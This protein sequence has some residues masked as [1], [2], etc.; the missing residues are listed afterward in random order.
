MVDHVADALHAIGLRD[1]LVEVGGELR[2]AGRRP[3][4][5]P[6][7]VRLDTAVEGI[8]SLP[9]TDR[10]VATSG[11]RWHAHAQGGRRWA[12]TIDPRS[13]EPA[14]AALSSVTVL[15]ARC[16]HADALTTALTVLGPVDGLA[17]AQHHG[18]GALFVCRDATGDARPVASAA[19]PAFAA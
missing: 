16:M 18:I 13:G 17:F 8:A 4:G 19:W 14:D 5:Q 1:F 9:L 15:H 7:R 11:D 3:D 2:G 12:H 6:W 10:A